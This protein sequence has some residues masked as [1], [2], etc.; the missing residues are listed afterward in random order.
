MSRLVFVN[1]FYPPD[2]PAT[3]LLLNDLAE[4]LAAAGNQVV[5]ITSCPMR[6]PENEV[7][8]GVTI[9][10]LRTLR[11]GNSG[12]LLSHAA[13]LI[14]F[15]G[16]LIWALARQV[17]SS[18]TV[19]FMTDP[20]LLSVL[21]QPVVLFRGAKALHWIQDI[22]PEV[23][24]RVSGNRLAQI[25]APVRDYTWRKSHG[26]VT[27]GRDMEKLL[28]A[29]RVAAR[30]RALVPNWAPAGITPLDASH[31]QKLK[32]EWGLQDKFVILYFGNFG[33]VHQLELILQ[34]AA[35]L[36]E[37]PSIQFCLVGPG[38]QKARLQDLALNMGLT[39]VSFHP[40]QPRERRSEVLALGD[41]HL[42][43]LKAGCE[44]VVFPSKLYGVCAAGKPVLFLGPIQC[45]FAR[46]IEKRKLGLVAGQDDFRTV[47][48]KIE[49]LAEDPAQLTSYEKAARTFYEEEGNAASAA[50]RWR[51]VLS[52]LKSGRALSSIDR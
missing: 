29:A 13:D 36:R 8:R 10:R 32:T 33:R 47:A 3:A 23:I 41:L 28:R 7:L 18:D 42:I 49:S 4:R 45:E 35:E 14:C 38:P 17:K 40:A 50:T 16:R 24:H 37:V 6:Q 26:C 21:A 5:V 51:N 22:Y 9:H 39:N 48:Q 30:N 20:P 15:S 11:L 2:N 31:A 44:D 52:N 27:L 1:R 46:L 12:S 34:L 19:I 43:T 25:L